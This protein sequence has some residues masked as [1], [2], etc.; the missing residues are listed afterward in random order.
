[1]NFMPIYQKYLAWRDRHFPMGNILRHTQYV[2]VFKTTNYCWYRCPH[3]CECSGPNNPRTFIPARTICSYLDQAHADPSFSNNV[4]FTG[5]EIMSAYRF[6]PA[7]YVPT[8]LNHSLDLG[9]GTDIKTNAA[10]V[11]A[12]FGEGIFQDLHHVISSHKAYSL[13]ISL[14]LDRYHKNALENNAAVIS[15]LAKMPNTNA[16]VHVSGF[17][18]HVD[19]FPALLER[20]KANGLKIDEVLCGSAGKFLP[21]VGGR[22]LLQ[23]SKGTLFD[24]GRARDM[25]WAH[26][27][28]FPQFQFLTADGMSL[29]AFDSAGRVTLGENSGRKISTSFLMRKNFNVYLKNLYHIRADLAKATWREETRARLLDGWRFNQ[30]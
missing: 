13:Q 20:I 12:G 6:G 26:H 18:N 24:G 8:L 19:M 25:E 7:D 22:I 10:W 30:R 23:Y 29:I 1:M 2:L 16:I 9:I 14:S 15:R 3:C 4:V 27:S 17:N 28:E 11:R 5:G 21:R